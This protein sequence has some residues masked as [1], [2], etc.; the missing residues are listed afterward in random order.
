MS[1][2]NYAPSIGDVTTTLSDVII[3]IVPSGKQFVNLIFRRLD[4]TNID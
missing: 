4:V 1:K 2:V 3:E